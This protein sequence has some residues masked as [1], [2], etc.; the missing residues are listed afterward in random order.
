MLVQ[1]CMRKGKIIGDSSKWV[2]YLLFREVKKLV[3]VS[4]VMFM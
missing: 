1:S 2:Y 3:R 4:I